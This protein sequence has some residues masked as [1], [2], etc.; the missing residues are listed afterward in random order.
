MEDAVI[1]LESFSAKY[2]QWQLNTHLNAELAGNLP[3]YNRDYFS[4]RQSEV[5][6]GIGEMKKSFIQ[7]WKKASEEIGF[8]LIMR[9]GFALGGK[10]SGFCEEEGAFEEQCKEA[11]AFSPQVLVE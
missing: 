3:G 5:F 8:P 7:L 11:F 9:A 4:N 2:E 6:F 1:N 10:G